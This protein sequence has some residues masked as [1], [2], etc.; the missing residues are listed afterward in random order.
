MNVPEI[1]TDQII[2]AMEKDKVVAWHKPWLSSLFRNAV[3]KKEY[4]G[5]NVLMLAIFGKD[6]WYMTPNQIRQHGGFIN[7]GSKAKTVVYCSK[8]EKEDKITGDVKKFFIYKYYNVF[9]LSETNGVKIKLPEFKKLNFEPIAE[10]ERIISASGVIIKHDGSS[11]HYT[12]ATHTI[13]MPPKEKFLSVAHYYATLFHELTHWTSKEVG[14]TLDGHFG[15][16]QYSKEELVAEIGANFLLCYCGIDTTN[17]FD[18][19]IAY[20]QSWSSKL[21]SEPKLI[22]SASS[23]A[24][25][26]FD[27]LMSKANPELNEKESE[28]NEV[29][30]SIVEE[31]SAELVAA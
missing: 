30:E 12:P 28:Q 24:N 4:R 8:V 27:W 23:Q 25:K 6:E 1:I 10:A 22:I 15:N 29:N 3:S 13:T 26:R 2:K 11:A 17:V 20:L 7:K 5:V 21:R 9:G 31:N 16:E 19:S 14:I 18:N